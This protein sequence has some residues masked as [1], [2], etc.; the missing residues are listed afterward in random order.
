MP[1]R[2]RWSAAV[3][4]TSPH[5]IYVASSWR[6]QL[7]PQVVSLLRSHG[8]QVYDFKRP[9]GGAGRGFQWA[10]AY[11]AGDLADADDYISALSHPAA[12][13]GFER[14]FAAMLTADTFVLVL[15]CGRSAHLELGWAVGAKKSTAVLLD[16]PCTPE[17]MYRMV[18]LVT[19]APADLIEW[20]APS[21]A[22][23]SHSVRTT[24]SLTEV[25]AP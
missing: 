7:Q 6:N 3:T 8:H 1:Y 22:E 16:N 11:L 19:A 25:S 23:T 13:H 10:D 5:N 14:D 24:K 21:N 2:K 15:P 17:L 9:D 4:A 12:I 18:D 20:L